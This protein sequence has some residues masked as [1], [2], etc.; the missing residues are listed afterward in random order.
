MNEK[1]TAKDLV[2]RLNQ[3]VAD[4]DIGVLRDA[5]E[6]GVGR[7]E[8]DRLLGEFSAFVREAIDREIVVD[9]SA[10]DQVDYGKVFH[11]WPGW[12]EFWRL[13]FEAWQ[14]QTLLEEQF[15]EIDDTKVLHYVRT[16][17]VGRGSGLEVEWTAWN[18]WT[19]CDG[20][21]V[22]MRQFNNHDEAM[23]AAERAD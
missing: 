16:R 20:R 10:I 23:A 9:M 13:W 3:L 11:G 14:D 4:V 18:Y 12:N 17:N 21:L 2:Q 19:A 7:E 8:Y 1:P 5:L 15:E 6:S 22:S